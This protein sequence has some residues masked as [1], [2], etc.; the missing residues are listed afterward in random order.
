MI[1]SRG[2]RGAP[3]GV[4][5]VWRVLVFALPGLW[6][7]GVVSWQLTHPTGIPAV[8]LLAAAPAIACAGSGR[9][10]C[11][12]LGGVC[13]AFA[14]VPLG[15]VE[16]EHGMGIRAGTCGAIF[17]VVVAGYLTTGRRLR[18]MRE[19]ERTREAA[20]AA[21]QVLLRPPP[22]RLDGLTVAAGHLSA[23]RGALMGGDLYE[24]LDTR[25]GVRVVIG[26]VRGHGLPAIGAVAALLGSFRE[27]AHDEPELSGVLRRLDR[28]MQRHLRERA[29]REPGAGG[30]VVDGGEPDGPLAEEFVTVLLLELRAGRRPTALNCGHPWPYLLTTAPDGAGHL[31]GA[32]HPDGTGSRDGHG[33][34]A[35]RAVRLA[36][37][38]PLPPLGAFPLP[39]E[40]PVVSC[41]R[42]G[43]GDTLV[44]HT[45]GAEDAR[46]ASGAF[47]PL[48]SALL[49]AAGGGSGT[50]CGPAAGADAVVGP[51]A[52]VE[53][54]CSALLRHARGRLR[55]DA[56]LLVL[57]CE[58]Q[59]IPAPAGAG[60][61]AGAEPVP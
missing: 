2:W 21:Q 57:R 43:G 59:R 52:I 3:R 37:A 31:D 8:Q 34:R 5:K 22:P 61:A 35:M 30:R 18:L 9:R 44:L 26:D 14:L 46:D 19:L 23:T 40:L 47:F 60:R 50:E 58:R 1:R 42:L 51:Q 48:G 20:T 32:G 45:D 4:P 56:A 15:S 29:D 13:A 55:D 53:Q 16:E 24:A 49:A 25:H 17:A 28:A 36:D 27:A 33:P 38:D 7:L 39:A 6:I 12:V 10:P 11:V 54:V 41:R